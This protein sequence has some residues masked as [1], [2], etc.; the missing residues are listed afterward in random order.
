MK[1]GDQ[2]G[3]F[4]VAADCPHCTNGNVFMTVCIDDPDQ[5][6]A[7]KEC[8]DLSESG[9][10]AFLHEIEMMRLQLL[11]GRMPEFYD[12]GQPGFR[13]VQGRVETGEVPWSDRRGGA[14]FLR[15]RLAHCR[16]LENG[17]C[18]QVGGDYGRSSGGRAPFGAFEHS[19]AAG[20]GLPEAQSAEDE[21]C[22]GG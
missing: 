19:E 1:I 15:T 20:S 6:V 9:K 16:C 10:A 17:D 7:I 11:P 4:R 2:V 14:V 8:N 21:C 12:S 22:K 13:S 18:L 5:V 3:G